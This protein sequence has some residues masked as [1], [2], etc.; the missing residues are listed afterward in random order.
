MNAVFKKELRDL[1]RWTPLGIV[2]GLVM[3]W[4]AIPT[5]V[6]TAVSIDRTLMSQLGLVAAVV[7]VAYGLWQSLFDTRNDARGYL[8]QRPVSPRQIFW[9]K[10]AAGAAAYAITLAVPVTVAAVY[11]QLQGLDRLP[12]SAAQVVP[13]LLFSIL[14][15]LL[16]PLVIWIVHRDARWVG[17]RMLPVVGTGAIIVLYNTIFTDQLF[18]ASWFGVAIVL[19]VCVSTGLVVFTASR[20]AFEHQSKLPPRLYHRWPSVA[21]TVGLLVSGWILWGGAIGFVGGLTSRSGDYVTYRLSMDSAGNWKQME[22]RAVKHNWNDIVD[23]VRDVDSNE[24]FAHVNGDSNE[25]HQSSLTQLWSVDHPLRPFTYLSSYES[26]KVVHGSYMLVKYRDRILIYSQRNRLLGVLTPSGFFN[27][28]DQAEGR[29]ENIELANTAHSPPMTGLHNSTNPM[30]ADD[31]GL[32]Q[33]SVGDSSVA[34]GVASFELRKVLDEKPDAM[35]M[36]LASDEAPATLWTVANDRL[37]RHEIESSTDAE[38]PQEGSEIIKATHR[39]DLPPIEIVETQT[40][41]IEPISHDRFPS[42]SIFRQADLSYAMSRNSHYEKPVEYF[43]VGETSLEK[44]GEVKLPKTEAYDEG[45][46]MAWALPPIVLAL[47]GLAAT[48]I[49]GTSPGGPLASIV[50]MTGLHVVLAGF[51]AFVLANRFDIRGRAKIL[52]VAGAAAWGFGTTIA[53]LA[54][55]RRPVKEPCPRCE[56]SR[57]VDLESCEHCNKP[58]D[59]PEQDGI[60]VFED[61][62]NAAVSPEYGN[63]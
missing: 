57:R 50:V 10:I 37:S 48:L 36:L 33:L 23:A 35:T 21:C 53:M 29:F 6:H 56:T 4:M 20:H 2:L 42:L 17:L 38:M 49:T 25:A 63:A 19:F 45:T 43:R 60:E 11:L 16:H 1:I 3:L 52:W 41:A 24:P 28:Y 58:W 9:G 14:I 44:L 39:I 32:Y 31:N 27:E 7:A 61:G 18:A 34:G 62:R 54:I 46:W 30:M 26:D 47:G 22:R 55:Y 8:L 13:F 51:A 5:Q 40:Y 59:A 12:T 15:F